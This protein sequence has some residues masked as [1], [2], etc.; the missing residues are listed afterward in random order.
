[1]TV[2]RPFEHGHRAVE[3]EH[4]RDDDDAE[5]DIERL[6]EIGAAVVIA[7][8]VADDRDRRGAEEQPELHFRQRRR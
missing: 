3:Q 8:Q 1:M 7:E 5:L 2:L 6:L 4:Q